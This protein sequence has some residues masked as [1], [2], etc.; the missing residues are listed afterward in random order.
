M[1][2]SPIVTSGDRYQMRNVVL[3]LGSSTT[4]PRRRAKGSPGPLETQY[5]HFSFLNPEKLTVGTNH[6][7]DVAER[8]LNI[9]PVALAEETRVAIAKWFADLQ[10]DTDRLATVDANL[11]R[12][13]REQTTTI[14][15]SD[16]GRIVCFNLGTRSST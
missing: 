4:E 13:V 9:H 2:L 5:D 15:D 1:P 10:N 11:P 12:L 7:Q 3:H 14:Q 6:N 16:L 8:T